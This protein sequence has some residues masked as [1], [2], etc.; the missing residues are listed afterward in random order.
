MATAVVAWWA[1]S[2]LGIEYGD[3]AFE[4]V[5]PSGVESAN[6]NVIYRRRLAS[7]IDLTTPPRLR[8]KC[9]NW[10]V[11]GPINTCREWKVEQQFLRRTATLVVVGPD[12]TQSEQAVRECLQTAAVVAAIA[13]LASGGSAAVAAAKAAFEVCLKLKLGAALGGVDISTRTNW[14]EWR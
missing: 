6:R 2:T 11:I 9:L 10:A 7:W 1:R 14:T 3:R 4:W 13:A 5:D 12:R 8:T